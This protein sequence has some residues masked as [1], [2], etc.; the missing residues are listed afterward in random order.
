V[1]KRRICCV[2]HE[3]RL[4]LAVYFMKWIVYVFDGCN[5][6]IPAAAGDADAA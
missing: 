2:Y 4:V 6:N 3:L 1:N 5:V